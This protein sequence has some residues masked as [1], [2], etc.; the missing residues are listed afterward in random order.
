MCGIGGIYLPD[1][2]VMT[3]SLVSALEATWTALEDRGRHASGFSWSPIEGDTTHAWKAALPASEAVECKVFNRAGLSV[4]SMLLHTRYT[5]QG[6]TR[7]NGNNHPVVR[8]GITLTHNGV[9][10]NDFEVF[11]HFGLERLHEVDTEAL[12]AALRHGGVE[13]L[14]DTLEGSFSIAWVDDTVSS[15][16]VNLLTNGRNPLVIGRTSEGCIVWASGLHHLESFDGGDSFH[17]LPF[18]H[19]TLNPSGII[20]SEWRSDRRSQPE[21]MTRHS[22]HAAWGSVQPRRVR[23]LPTP[24]PKP[25]RRREGPSQARKDAPLI[26][27]GFVFDESL[28]GWRR[29]T[30]EDWAAYFFPKD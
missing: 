12:N 6:S 29:A 8:E 5:T 22:R 20:S 15:Q 19:Y 25:S 7:N 2:V 16:Q 10:R 14:C 1:G 28:N 21:V 11:S 30:L 24:T 3:P 9:L 26:K 17:A 4:R 13:W 27:Q 18:K 23:P